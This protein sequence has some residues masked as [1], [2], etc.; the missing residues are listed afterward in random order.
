ME[1]QVGKLPLSAIDADM[2]VIPILA[3]LHFW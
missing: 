1:S 3:I 2:A